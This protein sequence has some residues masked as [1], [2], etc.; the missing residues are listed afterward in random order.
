MEVSTEELG[1]E[2]S[3][4][5]NFSIEH[6]TV[7]WAIYMSSRGEIKMSLKLM[8]FK[9][10]VCGFIVCEIFPHV[11]MPEMLQ[12]LKF[13]VGTFRENRSAKR[14]HDLLNRHG[15]TCKLILCGTSSIIS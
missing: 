14:L 8:T 6:Y 1:D 12:E 10:S 13:S 9:N 5:G 15:L 3:R 7:L 2:V 11:L 4:N